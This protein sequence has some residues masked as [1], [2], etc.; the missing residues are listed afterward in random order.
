MHTVLDIDIRRIESW[1]TACIGLEIEAD[2]FLYNMVRNIVGTLVQV[3]RGKQSVS[4]PSE[5]LAQKDRRKAGATAPPQGL[6]LL[7][8]HFR[9]EDQETDRRPEM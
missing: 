1:D 8:V 3:G 5:V 9:N 7:K 2:G 6:Y 4:W